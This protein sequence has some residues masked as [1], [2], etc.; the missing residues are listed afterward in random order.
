[1]CTSIVLVEISCSWS[2]KRLLGWNMFERSWLATHEFSL[3]MSDNQTKDLLLYSHYLR[4]RYLYIECSFE[5]SSF[6]LTA[7]NFTGAETVM[8]TIKHLKITTGFLIDVPLCHWWKMKCSSHLGFASLNRTFH[9]STHEGSWKYMYHRTHNH[10]LF[11]YYPSF[12]LSSS[13]L[14][15]SVLYSS[16]W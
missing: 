13:I 11:V 8:G 10:S 9:L 2:V 5:R 15:P 16:H 12:R 7:F 3:L 6:P 4:I 1:M 14:S